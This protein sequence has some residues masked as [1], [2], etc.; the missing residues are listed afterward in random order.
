MNEGI[1]LTLAALEE[2]DWSPHRLGQQLE[3]RSGPLS[4]GQI[5]RIL[6][7]ENERLPSLKVAVQI[8]NLLGVPCS[9]WTEGGGVLPDDDD[10]AA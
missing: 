7:P 10:A 8:E 1:R 6:D 2:R 3:G 9:A 4:A 5:Y